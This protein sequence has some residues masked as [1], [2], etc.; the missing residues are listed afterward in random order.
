MYQ[1]C[2]VANDCHVLPFVAVDS[3]SAFG[4]KGCHD[5][6][7]GE[8]CGE[9]PAG[10]RCP[11]QA[12]GEWTTRRAI[13]NFRAARHRR[14]VLF[15]KGKHG[16]DATVSFPFGSV[17]ATAIVAIPSLPIFETFSSRFPLEVQIRWSSEGLGLEQYTRAKRAVIDLVRQPTEQ[18][19]P[20]D[21]TTS[22]PP[23]Q[24]RRRRGN[25]PRRELR[26]SSAA[27][28]EGLL[29]PCC[30][31]PWLAKIHLVRMARKCCKIIDEKLALILNSLEPSLSLG[32]GESIRRPMH[33]PAPFS[34]RRSP[35]S[36]AVSPHETL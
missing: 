12:H 29:F 7:A 4:V 32:I 20:I 16:P 8:M 17:S 13:K 25:Q 19:A 9:S 36:R 23:S 1:F 24:S 26:S 14:I 3:A 2:L 21:S 5:D 18:L 15:R 10:H 28:T 22:Y 33:R 30:T 6:A 34:Q 31:S 27:A 35:L 11:Q